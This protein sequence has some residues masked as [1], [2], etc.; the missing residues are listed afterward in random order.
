MRVNWHFNHDRLYWISILMWVNFNGRIISRGL[1]LFLWAFLR[2]SFL[3]IGSIFDNQISLLLRRREGAFWRTWR[4]RILFFI[5]WKIYFR[6]LVGFLLGWRFGVISGCSYY[7]CFGYFDCFECCY[8]RVGVRWNCS[9]Y[10]LIIIIIVII[11]M[12]IVIIR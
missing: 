6:V 1:V 9:F 3:R 11:V 5:L 2:N 8:W 7:D 12:G 10:G 4:Q